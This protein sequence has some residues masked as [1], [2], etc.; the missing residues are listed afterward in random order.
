MFDKKSASPEEATSVYITSA[1]YNLCHFHVTYVTNIARMFLHT[2]EQIS[3]S[4][5]VSCKYHK[6]TYMI[7]LLYYNVIQPNKM[8]CIDETLEELEEEANYYIPTHCH[9]TPS[10]FCHHTSHMFLNCCGKGVK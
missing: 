9:K 7:D 10:S 5:E 2:C 3:K 6:R 4:V 1:Y 8:T